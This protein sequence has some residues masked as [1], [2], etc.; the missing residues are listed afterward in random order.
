MTEFRVYK[1]NTP[2]Y[3]LYKQMHKYQTLDYVIKKKK[4]YS[5]L[6]NQKLSMKDALSQLDNF[7]DPS[8][9]DLDIP[10]SIHAYQ[11]AERIRKLHPE[12]KE[13]QLTG[14]I[15][16]V[17]KILFT[18]GE[19]NWAIVG[20]TYVVGCKFPE[21]IVY[22]ETLQ[23]NPE[24][25]TY[26]K[27]GIYKE[28]CGLDNLHISFGHDEYLYQVLL[29]NKKKHK[30]SETLMDVIRY[31]SFYPWHTSGEYSHFMD[32]ED[33]IKLLNVNDF[34]QFDLYSKEDSQ[35]ISEE[36]KQYYD[37]LLD[38]YFPEILQW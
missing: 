37:S 30:F 16:D 15:H 5:V 7:I 20:D 22:Y 13:L 18:F 29:Q 38:E 35:E 11:T 6:N 33:D 19:P 9:P 36:V 8:D 25:K 4:Q 27:L 28:K 32:K 2:Q 23:D 1:T 12:N 24:F 10:N 26:D 34:N 3:E 21:S 31:H 14:L 17:G